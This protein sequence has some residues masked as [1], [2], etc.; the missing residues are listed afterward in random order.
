MSIFDN[1]PNGGY[2]RLGG[3][4]YGPDEIAEMRSTLERETGLDLGSMSNRGVVIN[5]VMARRGAEKE[6]S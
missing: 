6:E 2:Y 1:S 4:T 5:Y 3:Q